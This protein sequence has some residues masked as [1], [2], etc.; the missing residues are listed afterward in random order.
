MQ[1][2]F[3]PD[4]FL[5]FRLRNDNFWTEEETVVDENRAKRKHKKQLKKT[6]FTE[7][8]CSNMWKTCPYTHNI[9]INAAKPIER[10]GI[11]YMSNEQFEDERMNEKGVFCSSVFYQSQ[12]RVTRML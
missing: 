9:I 8:E 2:N 4:I 11:F 7:W 5:A 1:L 12:S 10:T 3:N 6:P